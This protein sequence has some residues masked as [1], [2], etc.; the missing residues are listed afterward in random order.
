MATFAKIRHILATFAKPR[1]SLSPLTNFRKTSTE[2]RHLPENGAKVTGSNP[3]PGA[4]RRV[5][6][7]ACEQKQGF[8]RGNAAK[9]CRIPGHR[10]ADSTT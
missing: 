6:L 9:R 5:E 1:K 10:M 8:W 3:A 2:I 4:F 7:Q